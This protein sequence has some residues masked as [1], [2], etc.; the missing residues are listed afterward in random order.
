MTRGAGCGRVRIERLAAS[1]DPARLR[2][3][4]WTGEGSDLAAWRSAEEDRW[5]VRTMWSPG[6]D[7]GRR[8][9]LRQDRSGR[10]L[11]RLEFDVSAGR[12]V[13]RDAGGRILADLPEI[14]ARDEPH[15]IPG[16]VVRLAWSG[17][18][19]VILGEAAQEVEAIC[20]QADHGSGTRE[21]WLARA[22]GEI[23]LGRA[24]RPPDC[25]LVAWRGGGTLLLGDPRR[26]LGGK[27][28]VR[29]LRGRGSP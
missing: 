5:L 16:G 3:W 8:T 18:V 10:L 11:D 24:G 28:E 22:I 4:M 21:Q 17:R 27:A 26:E 14:L 2:D 1:A 20:L 29:D 23:S 9:L 13:E 19:L 6:V 15:P 25:W 12:F 7:G